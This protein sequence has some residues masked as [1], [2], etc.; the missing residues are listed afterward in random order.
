MRTRNIVLAVSALTV[1]ATLPAKAASVM[2]SINPSASPPFVFYGGPLNIG[3]VYTANASY[4]LTG[5]STYFEP[6]PNGTGSRTITEQIWTARPDLGGT[7]LGQGTFTGNSATGGSLGATFPST[8]ITA[9]TTYFVDFLNT[10]GMGVN[11]GQWT[12]DGTD[13]GSKPS[14]GAVTNLGGWYSSSDAAGL[15]WSLVSGGAYYTTATGNVSFSEPILF[16]DGTPITPTPLPAALPLLAG[17]LG[18]LGL[19]GWRRKRKAA[20]AA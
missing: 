9:G 4:N 1:L 13:A 11:L 2:D 19:L 10:Q 17:G 20:L 14:A 3:W 16:F 15:T 12:G 18:A 6:V 8:P 7:L 5:I